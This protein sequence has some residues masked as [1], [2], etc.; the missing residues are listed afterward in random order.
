MLNLD[1]DIPRSLIIWLSDY[2]AYQICQGFRFLMIILVWKNSTIKMD[3]AFFKIDHK[4][5]DVTTYNWRKKLVCDNFEQDNTPECSSRN[6]GC[7]WV[8]QRWRK[9]IFRYS[10]NKGI[11]TDSGIHFD[12]LQTERPVNGKF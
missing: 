1:T 4:C 11:A 8:N 9:P 5:I 6:S 12:Y 2:K 3:A 7:F 10:L